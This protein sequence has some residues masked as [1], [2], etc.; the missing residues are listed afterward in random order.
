[1]LRQCSSWGTWSPHA[2]RP[3]QGKEEDGGGSVCQVCVG[4]MQFSFDLVY[5]M[6]SLARMY[7]IDFYYC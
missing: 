6:D 1:M 5:L 4:N 7:N 3:R 2:R